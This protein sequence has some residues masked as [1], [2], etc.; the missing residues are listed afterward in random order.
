LATIHDLCSDEAS[1]VGLE[2]EPSSRSPSDAPSPLR[3]RAAQR[4]GGLRSFST[5]ARVPVL[6]AE[7]AVHSPGGALGA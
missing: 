4:K 6:F 5:V 3:L 1:A 7:A 2:A